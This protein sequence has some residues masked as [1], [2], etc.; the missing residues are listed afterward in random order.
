MVGSDYVDTAPERGCYTPEIIAL[1]EHICPW[2]TG[3]NIRP[4]RSG[5][6]LS[7]YILDGLLRLMVVECIVTQCF[8]VQMNSYG[9]IISHFTSYNASELEVSLYLTFQLGLEM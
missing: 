9:R 7:Y 2:I 6:A 5:T 8:G 3:I 4:V 1:P